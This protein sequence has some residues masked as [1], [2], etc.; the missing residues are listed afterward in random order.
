MTPSTYTVSGHWIGGATVAASAGTLPAQL[1]RE[2]PVPAGYCP[3]KRFVH[4]E[5]GPL[6]L[7]CQ[8][9]VDPD[10]SQTLLVFTAVPGVGERREAAPAHRH[11]RSARLTPVSSAGTPAGPC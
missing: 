7:H 11:R 4:P 9:L 10:Q 8:T 1:W 5:V 6:E 3:A 2:H